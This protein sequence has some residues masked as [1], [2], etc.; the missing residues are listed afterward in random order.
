M[1][2]VDPLN[3]LVLLPALLALGGC[4]HV[5]RPPAGDGTLFEAGEP[6]PFAPVSVEIS[7][8]TRVEMGPRGEPVL[9]V[10]LRL[11]D[12]WGHGTKA[13]MSVNVQLLR[14]LG[15]GL[16]EGDQSLEW[17]VDLRDPT[18]N[19]QRF[20]VTGLY[21]LQLAGVPGWVLEPGRIGEVMRVA[22]YVQTVGPEGSAVAPRDTF[23]KLVTP[24]AGR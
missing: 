21:R 24:W 18:R 17:S 4:S 1:P 15:S 2:R 7:P 23:D 6:D 10:Y 19:S 13:P 22:V 8:L 16:A 3:S 20:D 9:A 5:A 14:V 12:E 11:V